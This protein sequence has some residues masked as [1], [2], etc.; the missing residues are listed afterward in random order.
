V[1]L[2]LRQASSDACAQF[3][4]IL[5]NSLLAK[6]GT[7]CR[8]GPIVEAF[9]NAFLGV[10]TPEVELLTAPKL[11]RGRR[12]DWLYERMVTTGRLKSLLSKNL[13]LP[14]VGSAN[15]RAILKLTVAHVEKVWEMR[16]D[17]NEVQS[18]A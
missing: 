4:R 14:D 1:G 7:V 12:F 8:D 18:I 16:R 2:E 10:L 13:D 6:G 15:L 5:A 17:S 3:S 11:K 9:P